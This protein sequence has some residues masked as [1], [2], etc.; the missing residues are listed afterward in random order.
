VPT[1]SFLETNVEQHYE[2]FACAGWQAIR[3]VRTPRVVTISAGGKGR[4]RKAGPIS[5]LHAM[6]EI[7][8]ESGAAI[9]H[10]RC[11]LF[12]ENF[13]SRVRSIGQG[14]VS[15]PMPGHIAIPMVAVTDIADAA[16]R[17]LV[18]RDWN[19]IEGVAVHGPE[20]LS[21]N[22]AAAVIER[23]LDRRV[24]YQEA[25]ANQYVRTLTDAGAS[26]GY[27]RSVVEMFSELAQGITRAEPRTVESTSQTTLAAWAQG[28][29]LPAVETVRPQ[30]EAAA[31]AGVSF[32]PVIPANDS[33]KF[34][35]RG[36]EY[37]TQRISPA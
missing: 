16:L 19:G 13:L 5:G 37:G 32:N 2:R 7:L 31:A 12:M 34:S 25:S 23:T 29:L 26:A 8:N 33:H 18:R 22:Q 30:L 11:G 14:F 20:D 27:A 1:E 28:E 24:R 17:W 3:E 21:Y 4:T 35:G 36:Y 9:R 15:Y 6:E 10:L